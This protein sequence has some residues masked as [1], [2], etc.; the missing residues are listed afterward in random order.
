ML[1]I[2]N[3]KHFLAVKNITKSELAKDQSVITHFCIV[4]TYCRFIAITVIIV[5]TEVQFTSLG[6]LK[7][8]QALL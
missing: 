4:S 7:E 1:I 6:N 8:L 2:V 3:F 5:I